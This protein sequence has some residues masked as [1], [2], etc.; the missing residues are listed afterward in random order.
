MNIFSIAEAKYYCGGFN[1]NCRTSNITLKDYLRSHRDNQLFQESTTEFD[2]LRCLS[3]KEVDRLLLLTASH[4]KRAHDLLADYSCAWAHVTMYYGTWYAAQAILAMFGA[5]IDCGKDAVV[6]S[7]Q[8]GIPGQQAISTRKSWRYIKNLSNVNG[9]HQRFW[10]LFYSTIASI[11]PLLPQP[12]SWVNGITPVL[13]DHTWLAKKRNDVN[14]D[15]LRTLNLACDFQRYFR[16]RKLRSTLPGDLK[17]QY[18]VMVS[19]TELVFYFAGKFD[20]QTDALD[21]FK[22]LGNR[23]KKIIER[24]V[25][26]KKHRILSKTNMCKLFC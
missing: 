13:N 16:S 18:N 14:Y 11:S 23:R 24:I 6:A 20:V 3:L 8:N 15:S 2:E 25:N 26:A 10:D 21:R 9:P 5:W 22:P 7:V 4:Y 17:I 19:I 12:N 1:R